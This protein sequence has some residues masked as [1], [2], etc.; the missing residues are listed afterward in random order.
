[1]IF[2]SSDQAEARARSELLLND[3]GSRDPF[4]EWLDQLDNEEQMGYS[5]S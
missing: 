1:M 2:E 5:S 4:Q 3:I